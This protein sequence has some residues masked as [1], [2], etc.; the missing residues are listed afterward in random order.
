MHVCVWVSKSEVE[1]ERERRTEHIHVAHGSSS[2]IV[3]ACFSCTSAL[4]RPLHLSFCNIKCCHSVIE[5][6]A[7]FRQ[8]RRMGCSPAHKDTPGPK[9][10]VKLVGECKP[11]S[12]LSGLTTG[13]TVVGDIVITS[14]DK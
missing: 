13:V 3:S 6:A 1:T 4:P 11:F 8:P 2:A 7:F 5:T 12:M 10:S 9:E 14:E